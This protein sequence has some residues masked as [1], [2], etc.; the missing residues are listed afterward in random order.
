MK[1]LKVILSLNLSSVVINVW[2][3]RFNRSTMYRGGDSSN[4]IEEFAIYGLSEAF[5]YIVGAFKILAALGILLGLFRK[6]LIIPSALLMALL[7]AVA[8]FMHF[9]VGDDIIKFLPAF[10]MLILSLSLFQL[11]RI[12]QSS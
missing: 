12:E 4:M 6:N 7:M 10:L 9:K 5:V 11:Q 1:T 2:I 8:L 3:F